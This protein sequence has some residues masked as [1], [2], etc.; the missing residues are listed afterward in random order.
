MREISK[1]LITCAPTGEESYMKPGGSLSEEVIERLKEISER[2]N[3]NILVKLKLH[4]A[5]F[6]ATLFSKFRGMWR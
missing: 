1:P 2:T 6:A 5:S 3:Y 4:K